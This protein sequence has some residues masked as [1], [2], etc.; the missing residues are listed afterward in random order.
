MDC[1]HLPTSA[2]GDPQR[3]EEPLTP[4]FPPLP[5]VLHLQT[6]ACARRVDSATQSRHHWRYASATTNRCPTLFLV[7]N[8]VHPKRWD[9]L[10]YT[11]WRLTH[12][13]SQTC[14]WK[15]VACLTLLS[16]SSL[17]VRIHW[18]RLGLCDREGTSQCWKVR[19][20][21]TIIHGSTKNSI[22]LEQRRNLARKNVRPLQIWSLDRVHN[23]KYCAH[24]RIRIYNCIMDT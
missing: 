24:V 1:T 22:M 16:Y 12:S 23:G 10:Y 13:C 8:R 14:V 7:V 6:G 3:R 20:Y 2:I 21:T 17:V 5:T 18:T 19:L 15:Q 9:S 4:I 11:N